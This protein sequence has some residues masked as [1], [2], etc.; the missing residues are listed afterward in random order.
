[1]WKQKTLGFFV[2][3]LGDDLLAT[4]MPLCLHPGSLLPPSGTSQPQLKQLPLKYLRVLL[5]LFP[6]KDSVIVTASVFS[7][8][9]ALFIL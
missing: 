1:M 8:E 9:D 4:G 3:R 5:F 6:R 7:R 2:S